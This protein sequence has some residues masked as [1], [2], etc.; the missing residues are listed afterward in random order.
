MGYQFWKIEVLQLQEDM[1]ICYCLKTNTLYLRNSERR[2]L[3][4]IF[5]NVIVNSYI[6]ENIY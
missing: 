4:V 3:F 5:T 1:Q 2:N 6:Y